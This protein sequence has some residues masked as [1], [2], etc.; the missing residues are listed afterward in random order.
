MFKYVEE[1]IDKTGRCN[2]AIRIFRSRLYRLYI[3]LILN[4]DNADVLVFAKL[5]KFL[6][7]ADN[8]LY[9]FLENSSFI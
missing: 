7:K 8:F 6:C 4:L 5:D 1:L 3:G 2:N 9:F